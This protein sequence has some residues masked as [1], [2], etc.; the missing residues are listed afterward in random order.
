[1]DA[2]DRLIP[3]D[4]SVYREFARLHRIAHTLLGSPVDRWS[5]DLYALAPG[6]WG[7]FDPRTSAVRL[8]EDRV[9]RYLTGSTSPDD[10]RKQAQAL[11]TVLHEATHTGMATDAPDEPNAVRSAHSL[12][13]M[14]GVAELRAVEDFALFSRTA[15]YRDLGYFQPEYPAAYSATDSLVNQASGISVPR[16]QLL[17]TVF[18]GP[19]AMHFDQFADAVLRN[20]LSEVVPDRADHRQAV[21][22]ALIPSLAHPYWPTIRQRPLEAGEHLADEIRQNLNAKV[23]EIHRHYSF[24]PRTVFPAESPN[25]AAVRRESPE[26]RTGPEPPRFLDGQAPASGAVRAKP[27]LGDGARRIGGPAGPK[28]SLRPASR[29]TE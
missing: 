25:A 29:S 20:R 16:R 28:V 24:T 2:W 22:A 4:S 8:A 3:R 11:A 15:G 10:P 5:G 9:L 26:R 1:M 19:G 17:D 21:R 13:I 18:R 6:T 7:G 14:E 27:S 12:G 23:D